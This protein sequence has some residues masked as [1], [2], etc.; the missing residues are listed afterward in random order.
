MGSFVKPI[1]CGP[2]GI[3]TLDLYSAIVALS[4]L[5]YRPFDFPASILAGRQRVVKQA[6]ATN[7]ATAKSGKGLNQKAN[8][9]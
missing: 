5:S 2:E 8:S 9:L 4:Q 7:R 3:R 1:T 6:A